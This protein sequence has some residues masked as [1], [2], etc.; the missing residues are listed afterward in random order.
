MKSILGWFISAMFGIGKWLELDFY[1]QNWST[2]MLLGNKIDSIAIPPYSRSMY[3]Y[4]TNQGNWA[5]RGFFL[6][7]KFSTSWA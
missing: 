4:T 2:G 1:R 5:L 7:G 6:I 3:S